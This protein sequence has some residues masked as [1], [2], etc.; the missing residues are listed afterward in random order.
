MGHSTLGPENAGPP[1]GEAEQKVILKKI[2]KSKF[3]G[4]RTE[5]VRVK[6]QGKGPNPADVNS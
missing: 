3:Q 2:Q 5:V 6:E 4:K 1:R